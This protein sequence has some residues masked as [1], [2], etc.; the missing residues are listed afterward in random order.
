VIPHLDNGDKDFAIQNCKK[1]L[2]LNPNTANR[3]EML[4]KLTAPELGHQ[5][6]LSG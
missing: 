1:S 2:Q 6:W 3:T 5:D 4:K